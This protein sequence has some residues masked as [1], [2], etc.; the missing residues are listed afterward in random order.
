M[1]QPKWFLH[2]DEDWMWRWFITNGFG[3]PLAVSRGAF[4]RREDALKNLRAARLAVM[5]L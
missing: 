5:S 2:M 1:E 4:F 3:Q